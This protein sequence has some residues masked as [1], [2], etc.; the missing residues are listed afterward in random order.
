[1]VLRLPRSLDGRRR[2][3]RTSTIDIPTAY[4]L[5]F[6][7]YAGKFRVTDAVLTPL[8][9][10]ATAL[11]GYDIALKALKDAGGWCRRRN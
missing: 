10:P 6:R 4:P 3:S 1:M 7:T 11:S 8:D 2:L 5:Y 9:A